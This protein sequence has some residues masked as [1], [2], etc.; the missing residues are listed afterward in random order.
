VV[1]AGSVSR[2]TLL[3]RGKGAGAASLSE[4]HYAGGRGVRP[5]PALRDRLAALYGVELGPA[6]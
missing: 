3:I 5:D 6:D 2:V 4:D 1:N